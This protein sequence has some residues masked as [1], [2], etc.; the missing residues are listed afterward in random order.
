MVEQ[1]QAFVNSRRSVLQYL[2]PVR[3]TTLLLVIVAA[4]SVL[5]TLSALE[6]KVDHPIRGDSIDYFF[7]A[8]NL[9]HS[10]VYSRSTESY[11]HW[12]AS[13]QPD[14]FRS[15]GYPFFLSAFVNGN[16]LYVFPGGEPNS[17]IVGR[18]ILS[19]AL[20]S[21]ATLLGVFY[22]CRG[23]LPVPLALVATS[24]TALSP[25]LIVMNS[26]VLTETLFC[27]LVVILA[28]ML[29][30]CGPAMPFW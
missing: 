22:V 13:V 12:N 24:L 2:L 28:Y 26:Y 4:G 19:Q 27:M 11:S 6:T 7:Y 23:F 29:N 25:H 9:R 5:R 3:T 16:P 18:I 30:S 15:P 14:A 21:M 17:T 20:I 10:A 1:G 8:Y